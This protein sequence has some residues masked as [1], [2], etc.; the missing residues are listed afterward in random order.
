MLYPG[1]EAGV[2][3]LGYERLVLGARYQIGNAQV[4]ADKTGVRSV[5]VKI[6]GRT[7]SML[8]LL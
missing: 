8:I 2:S 3:K 7:Q 1:K 5:E 4:R 6:D